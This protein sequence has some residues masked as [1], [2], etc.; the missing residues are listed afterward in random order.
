M[1]ITVIPWSEK[2][3]SDGSGLDPAIVKFLYYNSAEPDP[4]SQNQ[5]VTANTL[6]TL[7]GLNAAVTAANNGV[8]LS[9]TTVQ[10]GHAAAGTGASNFTANRFLYLAGFNLE[11]G[12]TITS[13]YLL[14]I[15]GTTGVTTIDSAFTDGAI[16]FGDTTIGKVNIITNSLGVT[17]TNVSGLVL[18]N[19][20]AAAAG[21]QQISPAIRQRANGWKTNST[22]A[23]QTIDFRHYVVPVQGAVSPTGYFTL[24]S[25]V[26]GASYV[27]GLAVDTTGAVIIGGTSSVTSS[28]LYVTRS[29]SRVL[30]DFVYTAADSSSG[31]PQVR[32]IQ[33]DGTLLD[34]SS[35]L[36]TYAFAGFNGTS[37]VTSAYI[38]AFN[39][40]AWSVTTNPTNI[41]FW[42]TRDS[43]S[44]TVP[45]FSLKIDPVGLYIGGPGTNTISAKLHI[46]QTV[47][48]D[49]IAVWRQ[50]GS[51]SSTNGALF[52]LGVND[53][54][55]M[56]SGDMLA[57][58]RLVGV[59]DNTGAFVGGA[60]IV[61]FAEAVWTPSTAPTYM[62][63]NTTPAGSLTRAEAMRIDSNGNLQLAKGFKPSVVTSS[64]GTLV[65]GNIVQYVNTGGAT[66][67][68]LPAIVA[69]VFQMYMIKNRGS[70]AITLNSNAGG[71]DI[72][73]TAAVATVTIN[74][75]EAFIFVSDGTYFLKQ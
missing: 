14:R 62:S 11:I 4:D 70:A 18:S 8:S 44:N 57:A 39:T 35:Q 49:N 54:S 42:T 1:A 46:D 48:G 26:N 65:L 17:Q 9:S 60:S 38:R 72:Y 29:D 37:I 32:L 24:E 10:L 23:T 75:G 20:T 16:I 25:S 53:G 22:A 19:T 40:S 68:T 64:A 50:M 33:N 36:G 15:N 41:Q 73:D 7:M 59:M 6:K 3:T 51:S 63:F 58:I 31:G 43:G 45:E 27:Q 69:G 34:A 47:A 28:K 61:A 74:A 21:A 66:T 5:L 56:A 30:A 12:A 55:A 52:Q 13:N 67:W 2:D 71:N